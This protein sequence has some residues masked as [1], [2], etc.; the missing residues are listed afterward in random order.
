MT[1]PKTIKEYKG[2]IL[3]TKY[4]RTYIKLKST[5]EWKLTS[6]RVSSNFE[7]WCDMND[8]INS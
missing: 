8:K 2:Y 1:P 7:N 4:G 5:G 3:G 6:H